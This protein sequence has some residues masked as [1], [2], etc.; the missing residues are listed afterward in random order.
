MWLK[1]TNSQRKPYNYSLSQGIFFIK[2]C[3]NPAMGK[4]F[5]FIEEIKRNLIIEQFDE[6][7]VFVAQIISDVEFPVYTSLLHDFH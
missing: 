1:Y 6:T 5:L 4:F 2:L 3:K 7:K